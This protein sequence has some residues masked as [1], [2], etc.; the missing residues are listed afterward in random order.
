MD[1]PGNLLD[2]CDGS[3]GVTIGLVRRALS[4]AYENLL[5]TEKLFEKLPFSF[6]HSLFQAIIEITHFGE[7]LLDEHENNARNLK[8]KNAKSLF[9]NKLKRLC[10]EALE[11][12]A[13][14]QI[15]DIEVD[16]LWSDR[17]TEAQENDVRSLI[18]YFAVA[19][20]STPKE[21]ATGYVKAIN[22]DAV[23]PDSQ[24]DKD[25]TGKSNPTGDDAMMTNEQLLE[26]LVAA[27][28][29]LGITKPAPSKFH[30]H[31]R[32]KVPFMALVDIITSVQKITGFA[33][34]LFKDKPELTTKEADRSEFF[35]R[36]TVCVDVFQ[37]RP[38]GRWKVD[39]L[40]ASGSTGSV[41]EDSLQNA[42]KLMLAFIRAGQECKA[43]GDGCVKKSADAVAMAINRNP[44]EFALPTD[45]A[46]TVETVS[47]ITG[48]SKGR[49][50]PSSETSEMDGLCVRMRAQKICNS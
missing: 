45:N 4:G 3:K 19:A 10:W 28:V 18:Q 12:D 27:A 13:N 11:L 39:A 26:L 8:E 6:V 25:S 17:L 23:I 35:A 36:V 30:K 24:S 2:M 50:I 34:D 48:A 38:K 31:F 44:Q 40:K 46:S 33:A 14:N 41:M 9:L 20:M 22:P 21:K 7:G 49:E 29:D 47:G 5:R 37:N 15:K 43:D 42:L 16:G 1:E 32:T